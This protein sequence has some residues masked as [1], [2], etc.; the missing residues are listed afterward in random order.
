MIVDFGGIY[1]SFVFCRRLGFTC[2]CNTGREFIHR[3]EEFTRFRCSSTSDITSI[4]LWHLDI[5]QHRLCLW[6]VRRAAGTP[7]RTLGSICLRLKTT[8]M[9]A[10]YKTVTEKPPRDAIVS[11]W[12]IRSSHLLNR[13]IHGRHLFLGFNFPRP[14]PPAISPIEWKE[15]L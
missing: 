6:R 9:Q 10:G 7:D 1:F 14:P 2:E 4:S 11:S 3:G 12:K 8:S 15:T 5:R 13:R